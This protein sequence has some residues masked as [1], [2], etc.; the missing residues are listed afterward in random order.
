MGL[1]MS[2]DD[3]NSRGDRQPHPV[4]LDAL[5]YLKARR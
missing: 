2:I 4:T 5:A 1:E 3:L